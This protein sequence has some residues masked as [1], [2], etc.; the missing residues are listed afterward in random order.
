MLN[1]LCEALKKPIMVYVKRD[2]GLI[3]FRY[4]YN[5]IYN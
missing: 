2:S 1:L 5:I 4:V 3:N